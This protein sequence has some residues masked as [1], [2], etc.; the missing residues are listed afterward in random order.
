MDSTSS[1]INYWGTRRSMKN[2]SSKSDLLIEIQHLV[3]KPIELGSL[4]ISELEAIRKSLSKGVKIKTE[5]C[6]DKK[7]YISHLKKA[8]PQ[9]KNGHRVPL[10][11]LK[12]LS[13]EFDETR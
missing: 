7:S 2:K 3:N 12:E 11:A 6:K 5:E 10:I 13:E 8:V 9:L 4:N 1:T